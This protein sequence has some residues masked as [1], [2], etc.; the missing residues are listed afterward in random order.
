MPNGA[1]PIKKNQRTGLGKYKKEKKQVQAR[2]M[3]Q[4]KKE[5]ADCQAVAHE[6]Q[7]WEF[8]L[9]AAL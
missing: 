5:T 4:R 8:L 2:G 1:I 3:E 7:D 6:A 9:N